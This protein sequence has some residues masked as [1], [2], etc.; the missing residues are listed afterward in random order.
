VTVA[1]LEVNLVDAKRRATTLTSPSTLA[2]KASKPAVTASTGTWKASKPAVTA[3]T[4]TI[5]LER[6]SLFVGER[7]EGWARHERTP[8]MLTEDWPTLDVLRLR[9]I[10]RVL[11]HNGG[12]KTR[13]ADMLGIDRRT[14]NRI[15]ARERAKAAAAARNY[16]PIQVGGRPQAG[17]A[18]GAAGPKPNGAAAVG[19][20]GNPV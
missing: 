17:Q 10:A 9:Y 6:G 5:K 13:A 14:L 2:W 8:A 12:N 15:L 20:H 18:N 7:R 16:R 4:G 19:P 3:S 1:A 11:E